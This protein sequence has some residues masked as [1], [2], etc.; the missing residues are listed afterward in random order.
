MD[1]KKVGKLI[2]DLR[3]EKEL[4]QKQLANIMNISD[5]TISKWERG[6]GCPDVSLLHEL[7]EIFSI[8]I[9]KILLGNLDSNCIDG[10]NMK[11]IRFYVC[12]NCGNIITSTGETE[13]SCCG[14]KLTALIAKTSDKEHS[15]QVQNIENDYYI[16]FSHE[17]SKTH[18]LNFVAYVTYDRI[19]LIRLYPEQG[20]EVRFP[21]LNGGKLYFCCNKH[22]LWINE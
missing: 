5:K 9:E 2:L 17:M 11:K 6:L 1:C 22:G 19:L 3:K 18:Y 15:L 13:L 4:T 7:S 10:G 21:K 14:R 16:T 20:G 8:N 12:P